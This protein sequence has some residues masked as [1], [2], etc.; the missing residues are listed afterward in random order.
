[1][2]FI[3]YRSD[4]KLKRTLNTNLWYIIIYITKKLN[5]KDKKKKKEIKLIIL[6]DK[7]NDASK[8]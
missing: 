2:Y 6:L 1:M 7:Y 8:V 4:H 5:V 3:N